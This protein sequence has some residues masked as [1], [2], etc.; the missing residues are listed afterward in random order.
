MAVEVVTLEASQRDRLPLDAIF[1]DH[2]F[3]PIDDKRRGIE[4]TREQV[5]T[6][7]VSGGLTTDPL[8]VASERCVDV[9]NSCCF[10]A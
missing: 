6:F 7:F 8:R 2:F 5:K 10:Q 3:E 9:L 1:R 4:V